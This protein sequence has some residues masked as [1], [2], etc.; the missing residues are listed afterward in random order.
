M[1]NYTPNDPT[2]DLVR[3]CD[4]ADGIAGG[5]CACLWSSGNWGTLSVF[6]MVLHTSRSMQPGG[7]QTGF[8]DGSVHFIDNT[9]A[10]ALW[11]AQATPAGGEPIS[12]P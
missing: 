9:I 4:Q 7:V 1:V 10:L 2:P 12:P 8:C 3:W 11:Q 5:E 6:N